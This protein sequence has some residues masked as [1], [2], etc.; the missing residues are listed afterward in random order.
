MNKSLTKHRISLLLFF[1]C[2]VVTQAQTGYKQVGESYITIAGTST[3]HEW[4]MTTNEPQIKANFE[5][6]TDGRPTQLKSL[7]LNVATQSLK[8][9]HKAMDKNAYSALK[10]A[11]N[12]AI[13]FYLTTA[14]IQN[15]T[16]QFSGNL[17][18]AGV[19]K[20][21]SLESSLVSNEDGSLNCT[22]KKAIKMSDFSVEAP[23]FMFG[24]V[25]T[26]DEI[27]ISFNVKLANSK[28]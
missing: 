16:I 19:T 11:K 14:S 17:S 23:S 13:T 9:A 25:K 15:N 4:T 3:L 21:L 12:K 2:I 5:V 26:G 24:S 8:S 6:G 10:E 7:S 20:P 28:N 1:A 18:I 22:G 27:T